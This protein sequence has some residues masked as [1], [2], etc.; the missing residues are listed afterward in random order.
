MTKRLE[1][2]AEKIRE[3]Q[4][5]KILKE[6]L[7]KVL[8]ETATL[9]HINIQVTSTQITA[10]RRRIY[11][12]AMSFQMTK[13]RRWNNEDWPGWLSDAWNRDRESPG[14]LNILTWP[15]P[16]EHLP[17]DERLFVQTPQGPV[18]VNWNDYI[19]MSNTGILGVEIHRSNIPQI[20]YPPEA[21]GTVQVG[22]GRDD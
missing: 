22:C 21:D 10:P 6:T 4:E 11:T 16:G 1:D 14:S 3:D 15:C 12:Q 9:P 17:H 20:E 19:T 13:Y 2:I 5:Y 7:E 8:D 18:V